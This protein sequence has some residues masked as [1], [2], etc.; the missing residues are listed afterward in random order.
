MCHYDG[1]EMAKKG[2]VFVSLTYRVG[3]LGFMAHEELSS[4]ADSG[5]SGNYGFLDQIAALEWVQK[6]S[7]SLG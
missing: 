2:V 7:I 1:E 5:T 4:E 6:T 3:A